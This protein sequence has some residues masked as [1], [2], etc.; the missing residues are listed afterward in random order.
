MNN[1]NKVQKNISTNKNTSV[2]F[3]DTELKEFKEIILKKLE[4]AKIDYELL[5]GAFTLSDD[6]GTNDTSTNFKLLE[7]AAE[8]SSKEE[9]AQHLE[10][11]RK[12]IEHLKNALIRI[13]NKNYG[14]C[15]VTGQLIPK[16]RLKSVPHA[17][18][19]INAKTHQE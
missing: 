16:E 1:E 14:I 5:K 4:Q 10:R 13:E 6:N 18:M 9:V 19:S 15:R 12:F 17:T 11:Q 8:V 7:D 2:R 3:S